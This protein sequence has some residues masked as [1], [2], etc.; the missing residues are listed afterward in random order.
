VLAAGAF[1]LTGIWISEAISELI[2]CAISLIM[3]YDFQRSTT[4]D[5][6]PKAEKFARF[7]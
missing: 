4:I 5:L 7:F 6:H 2:L 1:S 3:L